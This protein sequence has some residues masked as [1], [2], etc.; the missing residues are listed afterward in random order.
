MIEQQFE[1][2]FKANFS[3]LV[4]VAYAIVHDQDQAKDIVQQS[5]VRFWDKKD[6]VDIDDNIAAYLKRAVINTALNHLEKQK[7]VYLEE[8]FS[9]YLKVS[10]QNDLDDET[11]LAVIRK[12]TKQAI[13]QLPEKCQ[14]VFSLSRYEGMTNQEVAD[15]LKISVK[16]VEKHISKA[17]KDLRI[18]LKPYRNLAPVFFMFWV[19]F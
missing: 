17:I 11:R 4:R 14:L 13:E 6:T 18:V 16:A 3:A 2:I 5:F 10:E 1:Q 8:D 9:H 7:R 19:G 15:Y 12:V